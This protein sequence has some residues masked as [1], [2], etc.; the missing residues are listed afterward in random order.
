MQVR[1]SVRAGDSFELWAAEKRGCIVLADE[2]REERSAIK[3]G[4]PFQGLFMQIKL[5]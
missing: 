4:A 3:G 2:N 5:W 1:S